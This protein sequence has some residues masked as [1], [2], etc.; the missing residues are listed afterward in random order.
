[1]SRRVLVVANDH[2]GSSMAGPGIRSYRL[3][4]ELARDSQVTLVVPFR[5][6]LSSEAIEIV[7]DDPWDDRRMSQRVRGYDAVVAQAL[8]VSTMARLARCSTVAIYDLYD[9]VTIESL[10]WSA[11]HPKSRRGDALSRLTRLVQASSLA[12]GDAFIC[13]SERQRDLWLG[14]LATLGRLDRA[15]YEQDPSL[16]AVIDV[17]PFGTDVEPPRTDGP[18]IK[19]V[20]PGIAEADRVL[21]W[22]GGIWNWFDPLTLIHAVGR[23][24]ARRGDVKLYFLGLRHPNPGVPAMDMK[25][26]AIELARELDLTNRVVFFNSGWVPY[27]LRGAYFLEADI[28][29]SAHLD[30]I[31]SRFAF[32][33]RLL[34]CFWAGL[35]VVSTAGD[36]LSELVRER[37]LG[38]C[39]PVASVEAWVDALDGLLDAD[40]ER[41]RIRERCEA[42]R[43]ELAWSRVAQPLRALVSGSRSNS[44][45]LPPSLR[46]HYVSTRLE[47]A[48]LQHGL[49]ETGTRLVRRLTGTTRPLEGRVQP[50]LT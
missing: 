10:A 23:L 17:V 39:V 33:T 31:E 13:A 34:D 36:V 6:D 28:G 29:V 49:R 26:R 3:A 24:S 37:C 14:A 30:S 47:N 16:R 50:P 32:R 4:L 42:I 35:P 38:R 20:V 1:M 9:P 8:P 18:V 5:T 43:T 7:Q 27:E 45:P 19:G 48:L 41:A 22:G 15:A 44:R 21:L 12:C 25:N 2:V 46:A 11:G 40:D